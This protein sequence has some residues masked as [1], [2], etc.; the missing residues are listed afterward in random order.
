MV[1][2]KVEPKPH[3][4]NWVPKWV[5]AFSGQTAVWVGIIIVGKSC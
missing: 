2:P 1:E 4:L 3:F 5:V